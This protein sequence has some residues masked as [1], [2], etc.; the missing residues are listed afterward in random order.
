[1]AICNNSV[2]LGALTSES[3]CSTGCNKC[4]Q[5]K[6]VIAAKFEGVAARCGFCCSSEFPC[7]FVM[8]RSSHAHRASGNVAQGLETVVLPH[9]N[10]GPMQL[11]FAQRAVRI[12]AAAASMAKKV[13]TKVSPSIS[14]RPVRVIIDEAFFPAALDVSG[15]ARAEQSTFMALTFACFEEAGGAQLCIVALT[16]DPVLLFGS[17]DWFVPELVAQS[18]LACSVLPSL[19]FGAGPPPPGFCITA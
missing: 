18:A 3:P 8:P 5:K 17:S 9:K 13:A 16:S 14:S 15:A 11:C 10:F 19:L 7:I 1:M 12:T 2:F 6:A 4:L